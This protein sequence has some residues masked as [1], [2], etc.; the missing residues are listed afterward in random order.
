M[1]DDPLRPI[2]RYLLWTIAAL[3][4]LLLAACLTHSI[5]FPLGPLRMAAW[6]VYGAG[7]FPMRQK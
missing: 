5:L 1:A 3:F 4:L 2:G 7:S 6:T